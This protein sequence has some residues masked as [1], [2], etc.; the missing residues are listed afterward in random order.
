LRSVSPPSPQVIVQA[1]DEKL[2]TALLIEKSNDPITKTFEGVSMG[3]IWSIIKPDKKILFAGLLGSIAVGIT[4]PLMSILLSGLITIFY[5]TDIDELKEGANRNA[6]LFVG[7]AVWTFVS[8]YL[9][10]GT[11]GKVGSRLT[12]VIRFQMFSNMLKQEIAFFDDE[13]NSVGVL[14]TRLS[15]DTD[16]IRSV[17]T[18]WVSQLVQIFTMAFA[19]LFIAFITDWRLSLLLLLLSP[20]IALS[21]FGQMVFMRGTQ[22][23]QAFENAGNIASE[24]IS[25]AGTIA[26][27][28]AQQIAVSKFDKELVL[29]FKLSLKGSFMNG[30]ALGTSQ[31]LLFLAYSVSLWFGAYL[32]DEG[33]TNFDNVL[34]V[35]FAVIMSFQSIGRAAQRTPDFARA[36]IALKAVFEMIDRKTKIDPTIEAGG[37][38]TDIAKSTI[39]FDRVCFS[40]PSRPDA[41]VLESLDLVIEPGKSIGLVGFSGSGK[42]TIFALLERFYDASSGSIKID[43]CNIVDVNLY[44]LRDQLGFVSQEPVLFNTTI[45]NN[46]RYGKHDA[47]E[48]EMLNACEKANILKFVS[49]LPNGLDTVIGPRGNQLSGGQRQRI[50]IA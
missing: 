28:N 29:P 35:F 24:A 43:G 41:T 11:M 7:L 8:M 5:K 10:V 50:A 3:R 40:Y 2:D 30:L 49:D 21:G 38:S 48:E 27:F 19:G 15:S 9:Q 47:T 36:R 17:S 18:D 23:K 32:I 1:D 39:A 20:F 33:L 4:W 12:K 44:Q 13:R 45:R 31:F 34:R 16:L 6:L 46:L 25:G 14:N 26:S 42:S 37:K 22:E